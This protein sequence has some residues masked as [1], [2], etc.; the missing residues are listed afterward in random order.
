MKTLKFI[1]FIFFIG[2]LLGG[3]FLSMSAGAQSKA[4]TRPAVIINSYAVDRGPYGTIWKIYIEA[5]AGDAEMTKIGVMVDQPGTGRYPTDWI[6]LKPEYRKHLKGYLQWTLFSSKGEMKE[7]DYITVRIFITDKVGSESERVSFPFTFES[8]VGN[9]AK[10]PSPFDQGDVRKLGNI[11]A[12]LKRPGT[13][14]VD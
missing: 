6:Y 11:S 4:Q 10:L 2:L 13:G 1:C 9:Q 12:E 7:G 5:E 8:G 3:V 14:R